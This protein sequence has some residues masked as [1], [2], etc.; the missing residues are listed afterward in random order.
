[1]A[2]RRTDLIAR[3]AARLIES[4]RAETIADAVRAAAKSLGLAGVELPGPG[5]VR[6][7][8]RALAM[9]ALGDE[10]YAR[11]VEGVWRR[12]EQLMTVLAESMPDARPLLV[13]RAARGEIDAGVTIHVRLYTDAP[14]TEIAETL[15]GFGYGEPDFETAHTRLGRLS[16]VRLDDDGIDIVV[17]RCLPPMAESSHLDLFSGCPIET[18]TLTQ[19]RRRLVE[20]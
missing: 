16:R 11:R 14:I 9:Q 20:P 4:G 13:G 12:A 19:L 6:Q 10:S 3:E 7:H 18:A 15:A 17:T 5:R 8:A 2:D 1:M